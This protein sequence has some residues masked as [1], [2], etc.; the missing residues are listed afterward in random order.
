[1]L[2]TPPK[3]RPLQKAGA[4]FLSKHPKAYLAMRM[5]LGK[6][7]TALQQ[8]K[9]GTTTLIVCPVSVLYHW[10][11]EVELWRP[12]LSVEVLRTGRA[13]QGKTDVVVVP[14]SILVPL[15]QKGS[16][17]KPHYLIV[18]EVHYAKDFKAKRTKAVCHLIKNAERVAALT[19]TPI[20][21][22]VIELYP[23][24]N[25]MGAEFARTKISFGVRYCDAKQS[26]WH[27][28]LDY[29][30]ASNLEELRDKLTEWMFFSSGGYTAPVTTVFELEG[31]VSAEER[32]LIESVDWTAEDPKI[33]FEHLSLIRRMTGEDK[34][35]PAT[36]HILDCLE[37]KAKVV[38]FAH[39]TALIENLQ[40]EL[41]R[42]GIE[43]VRLTGSMKSADREAAVERFQTDEHCR[44]FI[45]NIQAAGEGISLAAADHCVFVEQDWKPGSMDQA[46]AR[47]ETADMDRTTTIDYLVKRGGI[48]S[49]LLAKIQEKREITQQALH[50]RGAINT[51]EKS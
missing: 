28:G 48:D 38:V 37:D 23:V 43:A 27:P 10:A 22:R 26:P 35:K 36:Q 12:D 29:T 8:A 4:A 24:L 16:L 42:N 20:P 40:L 30:G 44:V 32:M 7:A 51:G 34:L 17:K 15:L 3:L 45:G 5:R 9:P 25:A 31:K 11:R 19:G 50:D 21:N 14:Y 46:A 39:H 13:K 47:I 1:M 6:S 33:P 49:K 2:K 18:D 41:E